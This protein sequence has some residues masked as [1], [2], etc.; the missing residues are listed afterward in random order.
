VRSSGRPAY[1]VR[2]ARPAGARQPR[3]ETV[4]ANGGRAFWVVSG[5]DLNQRPVSQHCPAEVPNVATPGRLVNAIDLRLGDILVCS[6]GRRVTEPDVS[7]WHDKMKVHNLQVAELEND[8][9]GHSDT[10]A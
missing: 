9:G 8:A 6:N 2:P 3:G 7:V 5:E 4:E 10:R 1:A